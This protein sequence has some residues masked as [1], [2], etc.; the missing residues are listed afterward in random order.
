MDTREQQPYG[1]LAPGR[2]DRAV[3][4]LTSR[5]PANWLGL[6][7]AILLRRLV[8]MRLPAGA[9][10]VERWGLRLR[11]HPLDNGCEKGLLFTPQM[12]EPEERAELAREIARKP[13]GAPFVFVDVGGNVGLFSLFVAAESKG[14]ARIVAFE[15]ERTCPFDCMIGVID[16]MPST[17]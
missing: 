11:L 5:L 4:A 6:R 2:L 17:R 7:L 13:P 15:P 10:D 9:L 3:I 14:R 16:S 1:A 12:F 8:T